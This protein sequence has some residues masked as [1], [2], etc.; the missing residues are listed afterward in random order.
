MSPTLKGLPDSGV[1]KLPM[2]QGWAMW[3]TGLRGY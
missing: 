3:L 2:Q 1:C